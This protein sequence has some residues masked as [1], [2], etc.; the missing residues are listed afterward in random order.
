MEYSLFQS[1]MRVFQ[2]R[3]QKTT[4]RMQEVKSLMHTSILGTKMSI[5]L[6]KSGLEKLYMLICMIKTLVLSSGKM[7]S[8]LFI[9]QKF[10]SE[11]YGWIWMRLLTFVMVSV[12]L[13]WIIKIPIQSICMDSYMNLEIVLWLRNR[14][15]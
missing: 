12:Q 7:S 14:W 15:V 4:Q 3:F 13:G 1:L 9:V 11:G 2:L 8:I 10:H 6:V 5:L